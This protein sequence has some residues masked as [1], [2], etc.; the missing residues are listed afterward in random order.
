MDISFVIVFGICGLVGAAAILMLIERVKLL[1]AQCKVL[2]EWRQK[3]LDR[4]FNEEHVKVISDVE[5]GRLG[6]ITLK[7]VNVVAAKGTE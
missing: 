3:L 6:T 4:T 5:V 7:Y 1:E 2:R